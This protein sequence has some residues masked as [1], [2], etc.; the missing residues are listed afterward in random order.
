MILLPSYLPHAP[1]ITG[2]IVDKNNGS[3]GITSSV[4]YFLNGRFVRATEMPEQDVAAQNEAAKDHDDLTAWERHNHD[5]NRRRNTAVACQETVN[6]LRGE[7][8]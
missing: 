1:Q 5:C 8:G 2:V 6:F 4:C 3:D 7:E